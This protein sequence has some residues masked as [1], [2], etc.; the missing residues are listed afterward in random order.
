[1]K[2]NISIYMRCLKVIGSC[3]NKKQLQVANKYVILAFK[4][5]IIGVSDC[6]R[7]KTEINHRINELQ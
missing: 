4:N 1:M 3:R 6:A 2:T 7:L 5:N